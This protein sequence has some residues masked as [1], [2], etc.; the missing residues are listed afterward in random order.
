MDLIN[1]QLLEKSGS[2]S[3]DMLGTTCP[4]VYIIMDH[5]KNPSSAVKVVSVW[6][7]EGKVCLKETW[8]LY[9]SKESK[10]SRSPTKSK[11]E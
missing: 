5:L 3:K 10:L 4:S 6:I 9:R 7:L 11:T 2:A 1:Q 8:G